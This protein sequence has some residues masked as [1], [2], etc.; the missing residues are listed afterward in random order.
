MDE[1]IACYKKAIELDPKLAK[2]HYNLGACCRNKGELDEAIACFQKAIELDPKYATPTPTWAMRWR[3]RARWT[4]PSPAS[5]RPS[6]STRSSPCAHNYLGSALA[7]KGQV[8]EAIACYKKAIELDPKYAAAHNNLGAMLCDKK[9]DYEG[10]RLLPA[11]PSNST[12]RTPRPHNLGIALAGK[13]QLDEAI[14]CFRK[15]IELDPKN[16]M[17]QTNL[18]KAERLAAARD[19]LPAFRNGSY[20]PASNEERLGLVEWCLIKRLPLHGDRPVR[21]R[22]RRRH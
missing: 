6:N 15:A 11:R 3:A 14:A 2:A 12:R 1:A 18:A 16:A 21:R 7:G 9:R 22:L 17:V 10:R 5:R 19:M 8:D 4:R 13:G 20:T